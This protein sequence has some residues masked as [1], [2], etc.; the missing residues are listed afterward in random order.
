MLVKLT[1]LVILADLEQFVDVI[2][3]KSFLNNDCVALNDVRNC[4]QKLITSTNLF[5]KWV[6]KINESS[7]GNKLGGNASLSLLGILASHCST[8]AAARGTA[9]TGT[10][11]AASNGT[12]SSRAR[13]AAAASAT[14]LARSSVLSFTNT[15]R[16]GSV[17]F[18]TVVIGLSDF[19]VVI[20]LVVVSARW[21]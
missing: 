1:L 8:S 10:V 5:K 17:I 14:A 19:D 6:S 7:L 11:R 16:H 20:I 2:L 9:G 13:L 18:V 21:R 4:M 12:S 3:T 15:L